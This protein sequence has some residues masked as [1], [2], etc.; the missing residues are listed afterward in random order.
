MPEPPSATAPTAPPEATT[1]PPPLD[2][3]APADTATEEESSDVDQI[4][5]PPT[6][7]LPGLTGAGTVLA[8]SLFLVLRAHRRPH[9]RD[10]SPGAATEPP[11][12]DLC[13]PENDPPPHTT[14]T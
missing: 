6:W 12:Q 9:F 5:G 4:S 8:G 3:E 2:L 7:L 10:R 11:P 14:P 1:A 13:P